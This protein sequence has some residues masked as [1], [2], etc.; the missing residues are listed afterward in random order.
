MY[1]EAHWIA[2]TRSQSHGPSGATDIQMLDS[3]IVVLINKVLIILTMQSIKSK[4][5]PLKKKKKSLGGELFEHIY[6]YICKDTF[7]FLSP[8][9][10]R[11]Q[12]QR[13]QHNEFV[14]SGLETKLQW[15]GQQ[16]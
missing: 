14:E 10:K 6:I 1:C 12:V 9:G 4:T 13:L 16:S 8:K 15:V 2:F 5:K 3:Q 7:W 11:I